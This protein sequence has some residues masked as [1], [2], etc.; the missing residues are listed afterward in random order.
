MDILDWHR[1]ELSSRRVLALIK[2]LPRDSALQRELHGEAAEWSIT[3][4]LLAATVD[5]LAVANW[6][7]QC[8][9]G[10]EDSDQPDPPKP[11]PRP[12]GTDE[13]EGEEAEGQDVRSSEAETPEISP[14]H[15]VRF[16][17]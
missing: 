13:D 17:G 9:N 12:G 16:F 5:H 1:E 8:V 11:V 4:H 3:D 15:L 7:F 10:S 14:G 2:H 6:M